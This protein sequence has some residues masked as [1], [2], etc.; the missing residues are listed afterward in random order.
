MRFFSLSPS[1]HHADADGK[2]PTT[3]INELYFKVGVKGLR[4]W[5]GWTG[6]SLSC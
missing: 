6:G 3:E 1:F 4:E 5:E 2:V